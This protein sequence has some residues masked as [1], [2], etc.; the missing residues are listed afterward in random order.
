[1]P[2]QAETE[3]VFTITATALLTRDLTSPEPI[4]INHRRGRSASKPHVEQHTSQHAARPNTPLTPP[5]SPSTMPET[6]DVIQTIDATVREY[7][8][9]LLDTNAASKKL[10]ISLHTL[11]GIPFDT[12][13][14]FSDTFE[15]IA[16]HPENI[17]TPSLAAIAVRLVSTP[18]LL[19]RSFRDNAARHILTIIRQGHPRL[20][21]DY[22]I[23]G[24]AQ[25]YEQYDALNRIHFTACEHLQPLALPF[26]AL[27][28]LA[29]RRQTLM[30]SLNHGPIKTYLNPL[31]L[32]PVASSL[33]SLLG[34][35]EKTLAA[36][37]QLLQTNLQNLCETLEDELD[38]F[39][40]INTFIVQDYFL[41][42]LNNL[43]AA[44][45]AF[46]NTMADKFACAI[47]PP[48]PSFEIEKKYPLHQS[49]AKIELHVP[50][51]NSGPGT[52]QNVRAYCI[53][54]DCD[55]YSD[56][57][58]L[59]A[60]EPG[61][62]LLSI[63]ARV[64][65]PTASLEFDVVV[66][67]EVIGIP[68]V[69][70][71]AFSLRISCQRTDLNWSKLARQ[72][73]YNLEVAYDADFY[74]RR[75]TLD[76]ILQR[77]DPASMQSSYITGQKRVGKSSLAHA[78]A[79]RVRAGPHSDKYPVLYLECGEIRHSTGVATMEELGRRIESFVLDLL[80]R[81]I[82]WKEQN[83]SSSL[84]PLGKL[85]NLLNRDRPDTRLLIIVDEFD[86]INE[87]LYRYGDLANTF[88]LNMRTLASKKNLAFL[89]VGAERMPYVM[90]A[91]GEKLNKFQGDS[92]NSF[93]L[94]KEWVDYRSLIEN[95]LR[96]SVTI[97][98]A[99]V[100]KLFDYTGGHPYFTKVIC[101]AIFGRAV[102]FGDAEV[103]ATEVVKAAEEV[104]ANLDINAF[105]HYWRDG[106]RGDREEVEIISLNRCRMLVAWARTARVDRPHQS[107]ERSGK[108]LFGL[109][110]G[111]GR[112]P[113]VGRF[114]PAGRVSNAREHIPNYCKI[115]RR[116]VEGRGIFPPCQRP[117]RRRACGR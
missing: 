85:L 103:S 53:A 30:R 79:A 68:D 91:Q 8:S 88:F 86:E 116:L 64:K 28:D 38:T 66:D 81:G 87:D 55:V 117:T 112:R 34:L 11:A 58:R 13:R 16:T 24:S 51:A 114:G 101:S 42:L 93:D 94:S 76:K 72:Q 62:F 3:I 78:V 92:L 97:Y 17:S 33:N 35:T 57:T 18:K 99:A 96:D 47:S 49:N 10:R 80:P 45:Q 39:R 14:S 56:E 74:G 89:L 65:Q 82:A 60:I 7:T 59:G 75:D 2:K 69:Q 67:W 83:Y 107:R 20:L 109:I 90:S 84:T 115:V 71:I 31:G 41:S 6:F 29:A 27:H 73:P 4:G 113:V 110:T 105:A 40:G 106:I 25:T 70:S 95:P 54:D 26:A 100:R 46:Q 48:P 21:S 36:Q 77:L 44:I 63:V 5:E 104:I 43:D 9:S 32:Q 52:A 37:D 102:R 61:A 22:E 12:S 111:R 19:P 98:E 50:L 23:P 108:S 1:M 15:T